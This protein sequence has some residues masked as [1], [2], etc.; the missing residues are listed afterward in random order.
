[1]TSTLNQDRLAVNGFGAGAFGRSVGLG[2]RVASFRPSE[3]ILRELPLRVERAAQ[4]GE[5]DEQM[6]RF[7]RGV[8]GVPFFIVSDGKKR[9]KLSGAQPPEAFL[10]V[11]E[12]LGIDE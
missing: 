11:F 7:A 9:F 12:D 2:G 6:Q 10:E 3:L 8:S 4:L 5:L 1:M